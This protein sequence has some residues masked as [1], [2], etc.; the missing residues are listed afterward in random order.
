MGREADSQQASAPTAGHTST[1]AARSTSASRTWASGP[2]WDELGGTVP[3]RAVEF[4][5]WGPGFWVLVS[6]G[7]ARLIC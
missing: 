7:L 3:G 6:S 5:A 1:E 4:S 2:A